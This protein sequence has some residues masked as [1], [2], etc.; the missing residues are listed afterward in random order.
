MRRVN[1]VLA[2]A[3]LVMFLIHAVLGALQLIG[4][5]TVTMRAFAWIMMALVIVHVVISTVLT[6]KSIM[7]GRETGA[8]YFREN[9]LFW[10]RRISGFAVMV[11]LFFH[12]AAF[13]Y[14]DAG[15]Y[16]LAWFTT[17]RLITQLLLVASIGVHVISSIKPML[18]SFGI[19]SLKER[20]P[21]ILVALSFILLFAAAAFI[22]YYIR[23]NGV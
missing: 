18:I 10:A 13:S 21:E 20:A 4:F 16:R 22:I 12:V 19:K 15:V 2:M 7:T 1:A 9:R 23:W 11:L 5:G 17:A 14:T 3:I 8:F 6:V